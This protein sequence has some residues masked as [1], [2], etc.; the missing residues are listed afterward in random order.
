MNLNR[1]YTTLTVMA[2]PQRILGTLVLCCFMLNRMLSIKDPFHR[3][4][5]PRVPQERENDL[6]QLKFLMQTN[7]QRLFWKGTVSF[8]FR[9]FCVGCPRRPSP[10]Q[11]QVFKMYRNC[12]S[13]IGNPIH[14]SSFHL[15]VTVEPMP[16]LQFMLADVGILFVACC[17]IP[18]WEI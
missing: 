13:S 17:I 1:F 18:F 14:L 4:V 16:S 15:E 9:R 6:N 7:A 11:R 12:R 2:L 10:L 3:T 5:V 8:G